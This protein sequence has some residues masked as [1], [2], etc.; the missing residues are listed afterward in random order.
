[1]NVHWLKSRPRGF[2]LIELLVVIAII[3]LLVAMLLPLLRKM[4]EAA[5]TTV[6]LSN[7]RQISNGIQSYATANHGYIVPGGYYGYFDGWTQR[8]G[9]LWCGLLAFGRYVENGA[10]IDAGNFQSGPSSSWIADDEGETI[11]RCPNAMAYGSGGLIRPPQ[12]T[13]DPG[14]ARLIV[15]ADETTGQAMVTS[16][17]INCTPDIGY[18]W[19]PFRDLPE[20]NREHGRTDYRLIKLNQCRNS[21]RVVMVFDG[22]WEL[23]GL[24]PR[25]VNARHNNRTV[26]NLLMADGH[27]ESQLT[28]GLVRGDTAFVE[29]ADVQWM[30]DRS[31]TND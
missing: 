1:M 17:A 30:L 28:T 13:R 10:G 22:L 2:T 23:F 24:D 11:F 27:A 12:S 20:W 6:C 4:R 25:Y 18:G 31:T 15:R 5:R 3:T 14:G 26:T 19:K 8:G 9:G 16:Y 7:L 29:R 21:S